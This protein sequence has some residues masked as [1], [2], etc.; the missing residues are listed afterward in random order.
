LPRFEEVTTSALVQV[1][2]LAAWFTLFGLAA[3]VVYQLFV[4]GLRRTG[5][6]LGDDYLP[7]ASRIQLLLVTLGSALYLLTQ[8]LDGP[9]DVLD[10]PAPLLYILGGSNLAHLVS[11]AGVVQA[12]RNALRHDYTFTKETRL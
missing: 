8:T 4:T 1:I 5:L 6:L 10:V 7:S 11:R 9:G 12:A 2:R 3:V